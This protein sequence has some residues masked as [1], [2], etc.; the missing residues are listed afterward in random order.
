MPSTVD[1]QDPA[2]PKKPWNDDSPVNTNKLSF[3]MVS[4]WCRI[5]SI[6]SKSS[7]RVLGAYMSAWKLLNLACFGEMNMGVSHNRVDGSP[8]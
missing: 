3:V 5:S 7:K 4:K 2:P 1:G 8:F 6:H